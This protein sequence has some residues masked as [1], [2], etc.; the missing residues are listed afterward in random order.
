[1]PFTYEEVR[2]AA[3][4]AMLG[5]GNLP[6]GK[7][8]Q[9]VGLKDAVAMSLMGAQPGNMGYGLGHSGHHLNSGDV[10]LLR[11]VFWDLFRQ[12]YIT[13]GINEGN[14]G[15]PFYTL[16][17]FGTKMLSEGQPYRFTD[18][19][20]YLQMVKQH[21]PD[22]D[23]VAQAYLAEAVTA[24]H[25]G[26]LLAANVMLG[27]AAEHRFNLLVEAVAGNA[28]HGN[29]FKAA[30]EQRFALKR[31]N[32]FHKRLTTIVGNLPHAVGEDIDIQFTTIQSV[33]R[34]SRNEAGHPTGTS[35][36]RESTYVY[37]Q[38]FAPMAKK[39]YQLQQ[40]LCS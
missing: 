32:A 31:I 38:L 2:A 16:S 28:Q 4:N 35:P 30:L 12:G 24:F 1:M 29:H 10:E 27:V 36:D 19:T 21:A 5:R 40:H 3:V 18:T 34:I 8:N 7:P 26:C 20:S 17:R 39:L 14:A 37:L 22:L 23:D 9:W 15:W 13:L 33:I 11:E 6:H 25:A